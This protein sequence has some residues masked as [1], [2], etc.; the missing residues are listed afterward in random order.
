VNDGAAMLVLGIETTCDETAAAVVEK[1][2]ARAGKILSNVVLSQVND[3][4][5][6]RCFEAGMGVMCS[7][8]TTHPT[9]CAGRTL[10]ESG[11]GRFCCKSPKIPGDYFFERNEAKPYSPINMAPRPLAKP[12]VSLSAC[13]CRRCPISR[14]TSKREANLRF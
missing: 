8:F 2:D 4:R 9:G 13:G 14:N 1:P 10:H 5:C 12:P 3:R 6:L 7:I 11:P